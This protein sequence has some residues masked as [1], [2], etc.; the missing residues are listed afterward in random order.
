M[1]EHQYFESYEDS[2]KQEDIVYAL[3]LFDKIPVFSYATDYQITT[4][5]IFGIPLWRVRETKDEKNKQFNTRY[6]LLGLS[7]FK[8]DYE[9]D[10]T[11]DEDSSD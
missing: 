8:I 7:I 2:M 9:Y 3:Y 5:K 4:L 10:D 1:Y 6:Y 11:E